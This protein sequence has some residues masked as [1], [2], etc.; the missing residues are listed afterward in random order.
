M[1]LKVAIFCLIMLG[2]SALSSAQTI[3]TSYYESGKIQSTFYSSGNITE[4]VVYFE[5]GA[6]EQVA[7]F[8]DNQ[9]HG[10][11]QNFDESGKILKTSYYNE[12]EK[13]GV[14]TLWSALAEKYIVIDYAKSKPLASSSNIEARFE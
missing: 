13:I 11:W 7:T 14:W 3:K 9:P 10:T 8:K 1:R 6:I 2:I 5:T 12:G 4:R